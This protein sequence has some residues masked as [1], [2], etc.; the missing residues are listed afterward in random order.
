MRPGSVPPG[1]RVA[2]GN[3]VL[4]GGPT[5]ETPPRP[6]GGTEGL[7]VD[8]AGEEVRRCVRDVLLSRG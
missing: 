2:Q 3:C 6:E 4:Q 8:G 7:R 5:Q 1:L